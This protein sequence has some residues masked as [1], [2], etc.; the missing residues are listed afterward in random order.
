MSK[1]RKSDE[2]A[3]VERKKVAQKAEG[4]EC[5]Y[6]KSDEKHD[7]FLGFYRDG[8]NTTKKGGKKRRGKGSAEMNT[9]RTSSSPATQPSVSAS[10]RRLPLRGR[11]KR[12]P[13]IKGMKTP[14][15]G[16]KQ[17]VAG[18]TALRN[19][20]LRHSLIP[21]TLFKLKHGLA[22]KSQPVAKTDIKC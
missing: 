11:R 19:E 4:N 22:G 17:R 8:G 6:S 5:P 7:N 15:D 10:E 12:L 16:M 9:L 2:E 13:E 21:L 20:H 3:K 14:R 18:A 1:L